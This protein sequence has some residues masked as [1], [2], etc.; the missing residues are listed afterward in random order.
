[1]AT[2]SLNYD[3]L[4]RDRASRVFDNVGRSA[5]KTEGHFG[6]LGRTMGRVGLAA[7]GAL[8]AGIGSAAFGLHVMIAEARESAQVNRITE[9]RLKSTG[10]AAKVSAKQIG[11]LSQALSNKTGI[12]DE[13][14]QRGQNMLLTFT[15]IRNEV[16]KGNDVF[17]QASKTLIDLSTAMGTD[18][19]KA[20]IQ[21]GK[22][23]NDPIKGITALTRVGVAFTQQQKDQI[24][25]LVDSGNTL[26]AQKII[27]GELNKEFGGTAVAA[28]DP[29]QRLKTVLLNVAETLGTALLPGLNKAATFLAN[30]LPGA[31][32]VATQFVQTKIIPAF[33]AVSNYVTTNVL[34]VLSQLADFIVTKVVPV[35]S[36]IL[37]GAL[38][39]IRAGFGYVKRALDEN[40]SSVD[41]FLAGFR[42]VADFIGSKIVP[43][44]GPIL[45]AAFT[46]LGLAI[47]GGIRLV[48]DLW[49][50]FRTLAHIVLGAFGL[51]IDGAAR[52]FG[53]IPTIGGPLKRAAKGFDE[54]RARVEHSLD[55]IGAKGN[56]FG[57]AFAQGLANGIIARGNIAVAA[58]T[59]VAN[60]L[61]ASARA[62][63]AISSPS[64]VAIAIGEFF[65]QGLADGITAGGKKAVAAVVTL[66]D[67]VKSKLQGFKDSAKQLAATVGDSVRGVLNVSDIGASITTPGGTD[68]NGNPLPDTTRTPSVT[69]TVG[70]FAASARAF[71]DALAQMAR[72]KLAPSLIAAVA[73]AGPVSGLTAAQA[74]A[75]A[76]SADVASVNTS[77]GQ[78]NAAG[79]AAGQT[80]LST[81]RIPADIKREQETLDTLRRIEK[82][83]AGGQT[84]VLDKQGG[85]I[86]LR[87]VQ[88]EA[89][90]QARR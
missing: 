59:G 44:L 7:A 78:I 3:I 2:E 88:D 15:N 33:R 69:E 30:N 4:A 75:S 22:A 58:A 60:K 80:V 49:T 67:A 84:A 79:N 42:A 70:G 55:G 41:S 50:A 81:T 28:S 38:A 83:M 14:I 18:P 17:N 31:I 51:I 35:L 43:L 1:M 13:V 77:I 6:L 16:G 5:S 74:L 48:S 85:Q 37:T 29:L 66:M 46:V 45:K 73:A 20:A 57:T 36:G 52:A 76:S 34:P 63:L 72:K 40:R 54:F 21:L 11:D 25:T 82:A 86:I 19:Q 56:E 9:A 23:L 12:D 26:G 87:I 62:Q 10:D 32:Q 61:A 8:T 24:K 27:L 68:A 53:W 71:A 65:S 64:K 90:K 47:A 89:K 39:G